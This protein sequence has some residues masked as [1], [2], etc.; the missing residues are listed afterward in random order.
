MTVFV[1]Q[2]IKTGQVLL[3]MRLNL[4]YQNNNNLMKYC[5]PSTVKFEK[6]RQTKILVSLVPFLI[7][8][9]I[10]R[11]NYQTALILKRFYEKY[12]VSGNY[13]LPRVSPML[14]TMQTICLKQSFNIIHII[15]RGPPVMG[16]SLFIGPILWF[17]IMVRILPVQKQ[18]K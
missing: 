9:K 6:F 3:T 16:L 4:N 2:C 1:Q 12:F 14:S 17:R 15:H 13:F 10:S 7:I 5:K 8:F 11:D 18:K